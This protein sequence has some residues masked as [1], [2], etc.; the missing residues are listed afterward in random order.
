MNHQ[1][2]RAL[3]RASVAAPASLRSVPAVITRLYA[4][5]GNFGDGLKP[6]RRSVTVLSDDGRYAW[7]DLSGREKVARATQQSFNFVIVI[8][9]V[10]LT[11]RSSPL[12]EILHEQREAN[13]MDHRVVSSHFSI[14][15]SFH[16]TAG[17]GNSRRQSSASR[18][19]LGVPSFSVTDERSR[20]TVKI[21]TVDGPEVDL[22]RTS[23]Y[24]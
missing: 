17:H 18:R 1:A 23:F 20:H 15:R 7:G 14:R 5:Q 11:V 6:K 22:L 9:G 13:H 24:I 19:I 8:A 16:R 10:V 4:T 21:P 2:L 3:P 12:T